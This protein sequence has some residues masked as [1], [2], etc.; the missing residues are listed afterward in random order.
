[1]NGGYSLM[2]I[3]KSDDHARPSLRKRSA[4]ALVPF[5]SMGLP[6]GLL[7]ATSGRGV[8]IGVLVMYLAGG[9]PAVLLVILPNRQSHFSE[10]KPRED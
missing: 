8:I 3:T 5:I 10:T 9:L 7:T 1:M 4:L 6:L 2:N